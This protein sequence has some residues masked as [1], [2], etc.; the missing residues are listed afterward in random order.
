MGNMPLSCNAM[1]HVNV[2]LNTGSIFSN[3]I[4]LEQVKNETKAGVPL[5]KDLSSLP[6]ISV[7]K[8]TSISY[9]R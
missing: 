1:L 2:F 3:L 8:I 5:A 9:N 7:C 6:H 4:L